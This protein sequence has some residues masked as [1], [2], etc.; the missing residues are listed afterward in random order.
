ML[1]RGRSGEKSGTLGVACKVRR[2][3]RAVVEAGVAVVR[4]ARPATVGIHESLATSPAGARIVARV[5][6]RLVSVAEIRAIDGL[7]DLGR[8][9]TPD[10]QY[11][12]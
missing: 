10:G 1:D 4:S 12:N 8:G 7:V 11:A 3:A 9:I 5:E 2:R 6:A